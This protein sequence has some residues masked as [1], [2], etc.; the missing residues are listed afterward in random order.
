MDHLRTLAHHVTPVI[1]LVTDERLRTALTASF[2]RSGEAVN[3]IETCFATIAEG[4]WSPNTIA[5][6]LHSW[7]AS[8]LKMLAIY[9]LSCRIQRL[10][11]VAEGEVRDDLF[12]AAARN[13]DTSHED[14]GLD[15]DGETH[16]ELFD[17]FATAFHGSSDWQA[18]RYG[19]E[20]ALTFK[21]WI[22]RNMVVEDIPRA[23]LT[24]MFSEIYNHAEYSIALP[25][26]GELAD[27]CYDFSPEQRERA[28]TYIGAHVENETEVD[29]FMVVVEA[30][31]RYNRATGGSI[32]YAAAEDLFTEYLQRL[33]AIMQTLTSLMNS[34]RNHVTSGERHAE[35]TPAGALL[36]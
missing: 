25:A 34:E 9:G 22:Y 30:L 26:F 2:A 6:F 12:M 28:L 15:F 13:A 4:P 21:R 7:K 36:R 33:G 32:D 3:A 18:E 23:L 11:V 29:H 24:N 27:R 1:A 20:P 31:T 19:V 5:T 8:H 10:A 17:E 16:A 14:L 35:G